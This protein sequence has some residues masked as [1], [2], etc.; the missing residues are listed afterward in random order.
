M[1]RRF[2]RPYAKA[3]MDVVG[4]AQRA[5]ALLEELRRF[6]QTRKVAPELHIARVAGQSHVLFCREQGFLDAEDVLGIC[7]ACHKAYE[8]AVLLPQASP[9]ARFDIQDWLPLDP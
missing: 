1:I 7:R 6:E 9:H 8:E 4:D 3:V 5:A 2:A